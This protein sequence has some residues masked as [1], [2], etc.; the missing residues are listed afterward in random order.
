MKSGVKEVK[1]RKRA[2]AKA[3]GRIRHRGNVDAP[4]DVSLATVRSQ[5]HYETAGE[6]EPE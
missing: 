1:V 3:R 4:W 6:A 2:K 5:R